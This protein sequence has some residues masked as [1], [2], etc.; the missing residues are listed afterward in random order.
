MGS[1]RYPAT[2]PGRATR[3]SPAFP[4]LVQS[5]ASTF[6]LISQ[7]QHALVSG[8]LAHAWRGVT[9]KTTA[10]H[11]LLVQTIG[12]HDN[13]WRHADE[14]PQWNA[15]TGAPHDFVS[16]SMEE[17]LILYGGGIDQLERV[18]PY[19]ATLI[20]L[21]YTT[22][23]GTINSDT[24]QAQ[25]RRRR[26]R[27]RELLPETL[28]SEERWQRDLAFLKL[29]DNLSLFI[30]LTAP[31]VDSESVPRWIDP[32]IWAKDPESGATFSLDWLDR[33]SLSLHPFPFAGA[34]NL[35]FYYREIPRKPYA[36]N[37]ELQ[38]AWDLA[39]P[40]RWTVELSG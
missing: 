13:P 16:I 1:T 6:R 36:S 25:E 3:Q 37:R 9:A 15:A 11:G 12:L 40:E 29:F 31:F 2:V 18:H 35:H 27:L 8:M 39:T 33:Q 4:M 26:A 14:R 10:L 5:L 38:Q 30:C 32:S 23:A 19:A 21:H 7:E 24:L 34:Q 17:K 20:S 22:F 28:Q